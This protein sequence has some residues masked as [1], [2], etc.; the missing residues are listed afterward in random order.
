[1]ASER[2]QPVKLGRALGSKVGALISIVSPRTFTRWLNADKALVWR[3]AL[4][5][6]WTLRACWNPA[7]LV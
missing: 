1:M 4:G 7:G 3:V 2:R 6:S 5:R